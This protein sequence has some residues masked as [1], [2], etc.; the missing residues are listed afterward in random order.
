MSYPVHNTGKVHDQ[1]DGTFTCTYKNNKGILVSPGTANGTATL[2]MFS[3]PGGGED[4]DTFGIAWTANTRP[5]VIPIRIKAVTAFTGTA[6]SI[7]ELL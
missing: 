6:A 1:G 7:T 5:F 2:K 3:Y 4:G